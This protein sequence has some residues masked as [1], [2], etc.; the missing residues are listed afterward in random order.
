MWLVDDATVTHDV[1]T[2]MSSSRIAS[3]VL[4]WAGCRSS[5]ARAGFVGWVVR[6]CR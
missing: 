5:G 1:A 6:R 3:V 4:F 2:G